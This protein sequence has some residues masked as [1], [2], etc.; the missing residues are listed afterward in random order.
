MPRAASITAWEYSSSNVEWLRAELS[1]GTFRPEW[2][3]F[4]KVAVDAYGSEDDLPD[5]PHA[6]AAGEGFRSAG[7]DFRSSR[8]AVGCGNHVLLRPIH[9]P[10]AQR[11]RGRVRPVCDMRQARGRVGRGVPRRFFRIYRRGYDISRIGDVGGG[12]PG[13]VRFNF[14]PNS[15]R[16]GSASWSGRSAAA[17]PAWSFCRR[18]PPERRLGSGRTGRI[19]APPPM[20]SIPISVRDRSPARACPAVAARPA[21]ACDWD[22]RFH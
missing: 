9:H 14:Q 20:T 17:I 19:A 3:H 15:T 12:H 13:G 10:R 18:R 8:A 1:S 22:L 7:I 5:N 16:K 21:S 6:D 4:W 11:L 2:Q